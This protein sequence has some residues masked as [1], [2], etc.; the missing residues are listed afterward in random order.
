[1]VLFGD[2]AGAVVIGSGRTGA[3]SDGPA[4][5]GPEALRGN[6][7]AT[8]LRSFGE[9]RALIEVPPGGCFTMQGRAVREFVTNR[10]PGLVHDFLRDHGV[11]PVNVAHVVPHQANG[12]LLDELA[13][14]LDLPNAVM[15]RTVETFGNTGAASVPITL[16]AAA[17][18]GRLRPGEVVLLL[19]FGGGMAA[20][21]AALTW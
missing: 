6:V 13:S 19:A 1:V 20:G 21:L 9:D 4:E 8:R 17:R 11:D 7:F 15:H 5:A 10:V 14:T 3:A 12:V 2:G 18:R 16:D